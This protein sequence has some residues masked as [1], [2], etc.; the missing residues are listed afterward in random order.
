[1]KSGLSIERNVQN[2]IL[3]L[4]CVLNSL[5]LFVCDVCDVLYL[6]CYF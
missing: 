2:E 6:F 5:F 3:Y 1:M 4:I